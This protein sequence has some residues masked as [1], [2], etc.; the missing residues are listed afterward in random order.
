MILDEE[1][2]KGLF[3]LC[4]RHCQHLTWLKFGEVPLDILIDVN[5]F[6][7]LELR[8]ETTQ[9]VETKYVE[10]SIVDACERYHLQIAKIWLPDQ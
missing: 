7:L 10:P 3:T 4:Q 1:H 6:N 9:G 5:Y 8:P 2:A